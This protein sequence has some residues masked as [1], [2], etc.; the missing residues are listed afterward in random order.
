MRTVQAQHTTIDDFFTAGDTV[1]ASN[2]AEAATTFFYTQQTGAESCSWT[3]TDGAKTAVLNFAGE[4]CTKSD[5][6]I[7]ATNSGASTVIKFV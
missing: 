2:F 1:L 5:F 4:P 3:L 7:E 6:S